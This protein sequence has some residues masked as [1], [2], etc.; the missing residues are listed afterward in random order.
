MKTII[1]LDVINNKH[2]TEWFLFLLSMYYIPLVLLET[3]GNGYLDEV[4]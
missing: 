1:Y 4:S 3:K 2:I